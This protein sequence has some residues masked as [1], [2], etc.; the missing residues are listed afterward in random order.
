MLWDQEGHYRQREQHVQGYKVR[1]RLGC[2]LKVSSMYNM[3][4]TILRTRHTQKVSKQ[5]LKYSKE[6]ENFK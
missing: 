1:E 4:S 5:I 2:F 6:D 3:L